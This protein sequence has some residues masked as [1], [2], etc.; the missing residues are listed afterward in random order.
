ML[1]RDLI[2]EYTDEP[3][4]TTSNETNIVSISREQIVMDRWVELET[5]HSDWGQDQVREQ[6]KEEGYEW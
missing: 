1:I 3:V 5:E 2:G 4:I 6:L